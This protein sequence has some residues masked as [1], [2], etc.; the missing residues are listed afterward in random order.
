MLLGLGDNT[1]VHASALHGRDV[2]FAHTDLDFMASTSQYLIIAQTF[3]QVLGRNKP[4]G[5]EAW[6]GH[7]QQ[8]WTC[9]AADT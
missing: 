3:L 2:T 5:V 6:L 1:T 7:V 8:T 4:K 9:S